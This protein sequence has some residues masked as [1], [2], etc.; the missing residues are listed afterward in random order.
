[1]CFP[2][3]TYDVQH[4][5]LGF[6]S[7]QAGSLTLPPGA[8]LNFTLPE[9]IRGH[10]F[11]HPPTMASYHENATAEISSVLRGQMVTLSWPQAVGYF[12]ALVPNDPAPAVCLF[13]QTDFKGDVACFGPGGGNLP[14]PV[15]NNTRPIQLH[16]G[17]SVWI[18]ADYY[19]DLGGASITL[20]ISDLANEVYGPDQSTFSKRIVAMW[21]SSSM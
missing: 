11:V 6:D 16:G 9:L 18:Y 12:D 7:L 13:E 10:Q 20:D 3:G 2:N 5:S 17:V 15:Q 1:M 8:Q 4:G 21:A 14:A 19:G